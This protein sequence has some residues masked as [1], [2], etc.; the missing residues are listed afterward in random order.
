[1]RCSCVTSGLP[2]RR[3]RRWKAGTCCPACSGRSTRRSS[4][5][6]RTGRA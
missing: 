5:A 6:A 4:T 1:M 3:S 2:G